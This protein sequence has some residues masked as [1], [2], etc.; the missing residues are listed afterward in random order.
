[1]IR[2]HRQRGAWAWMTLTPGAPPTPPPPTET[3]PILPMD[4]LEFD[5]TGRLSAEEE[6]PSPVGVEGCP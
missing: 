2:L 3:P 6:G 4:E 5:E 1:M